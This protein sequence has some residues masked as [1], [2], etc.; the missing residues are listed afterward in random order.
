MQY[1]A[2]TLIQ[3]EHEALGSV[4]RALRDI[5]D[6]ARKSGRP[7]DFDIMRAMLFY[8]DEMPARLHHTVE[9]ELLFPR[10]RERCPP[11]RPVLDR[12][13]AEHGRGEV[14]VQDLERALTAWELMGNER[15]EAFELPLHAYVQGYLGHMEVEENYVL[16]VAQEYLS[17]AD[18]RELNSA[19]ERQRGT[20]AESTVQ[21]HRALLTRVLSLQH[22]PEPP[23]QTS[24]CRS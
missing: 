10:I 15:R 8:M 6:A 17:E 9:E 13:E 24:K 1:R 14:A 19:F 12:L 5:T 18:W 11:L 3:E 23:C 4:L 7:P 22:L 20:L 2:I 16:S 21:A